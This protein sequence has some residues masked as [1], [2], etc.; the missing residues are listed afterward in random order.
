MCSKPRVRVSGDVLGPDGYCFRRHVVRAQVADA[1]N[2]QL[3]HV[4]KT[5][6]KNDPSL[7][8]AE[9]SANK[10]LAGGIQGFRPPKAT[11]GFPEALLPALV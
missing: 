4:R 5:D 1:R 9:A 10:V 7:D 2:A 8:T 3:K 6:G 11:L